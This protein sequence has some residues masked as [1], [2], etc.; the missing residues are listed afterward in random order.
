[1]TKRNPMDDEAYQR[2]QI[3]GPLFQLRQQRDDLKALVRKLRTALQQ[4]K[5][6]T[7]AYG[8]EATDAEMREFYVMRNNASDVI[9]T[10]AEPEAKT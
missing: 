1:M 5:A 6:A 7:N 4:L 3:L 9:A 8:Q 2:G 10:S